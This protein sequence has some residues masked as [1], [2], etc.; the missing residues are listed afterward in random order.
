MKT[1]YLQTPVLLIAFNRPETTL[2]VLNAIR[3]VRPTKLFFAV[4]GPRHNRLDD[5]EKC[6]KTREIIN[7]VDWPCEVKTLFQEKNLGCGPGPVTAINW[8]FQNVSEGI[9]LEDDC[10][11]DISFFIFCQELLE[12]YRTNDKIMHISGNN[13]QL[14]KKR[15]N[16]SYYFSEYTHNWGWAT[17]ARA[18][19]YN[20]FEMIGFEKRNHI[21][22]KQWLMS[23]R[24]HHG[25]AILPNVNLVSNI[26]YGEGA[27]HTQKITEQMNLP[28]LR[29]KFPLTHPRVIRQQIDA[30]LLTFRTIFHGSTS[31]FVFQLLSKRLP[32]SFRA[33][34]KSLLK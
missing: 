17:W 15:G 21:W 24:K 34:I 25:L 8:F 14:G 22:D 19:K 4:D 30:D 3:Q 32:D 7:R 10:V 11:P 16:A 5:E 12:K 6:A 28:S 29:M 1:A 23:V 9:I 33:S 31:S 13:F 18:W 2:Q 27:T 20:D 26:G